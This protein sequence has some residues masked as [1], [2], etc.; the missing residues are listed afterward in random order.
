MRQHIVSGLWA[1]GLTILVAIALR[2]ASGSTID[3]V[4]TAPLMPAFALA[5]WLGVRGGPDGMP[6]MLYVFGL[7]FLYM[8]LRRHRI[9]CSIDSLSP[10]GWTVRPG[11]PSNGLYP[12]AASPKAHSS[13]H[14]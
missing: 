1:A 12:S 8:M 9:P 6:S 5:T 10:N 3:P 13:A 2:F 14:Q 7:S 11:D 4:F